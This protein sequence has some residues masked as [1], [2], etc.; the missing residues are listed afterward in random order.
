[1]ANGVSYNVLV[2]PP[3]IDRCSGDFPVFIDGFEN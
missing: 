2:L 1:M 3:Q